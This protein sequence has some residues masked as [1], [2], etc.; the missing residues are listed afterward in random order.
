MAAISFSRG[1]KVWEK[2]IGLS[3]D[4]GR[5]IE[6][7]LGSGYYSGSLVVAIKTLTGVW[8]QYIPTKE[9]TIFTMDSEV[10]YEIQKTTI[11]GKFDVEFVDLTFN[12]NGVYLMLW[13]KQEL[14]PHPL[15]DSQWTNQ[16]LE[17]PDA[18]K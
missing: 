14:F 2:A 1:I 3:A 10:G 18:Y 9:I 13:F 17:N 11:G 5:N 15:F 16:N 7:Y 8:N 12:M 6:D 4:I